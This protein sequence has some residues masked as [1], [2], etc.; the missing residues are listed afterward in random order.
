MAPSVPPSLLQLIDIASA[1]GAAPVADEA[2]ELAD[3]VS[4]GRFFVACVGQ[5]K[6]G[7]STFLNAL[8]GDEVL[9]VGMVPVTAAITVISHG[10]RRGARVRFLDGSS[11]PITWSEVHEYIAEEQNPANAKQ[12]A[13]VEI[14]W[15]SPVLAD[16][17]CLVDTP[18]IGSVFSW[19]TET[20]RAFMPHVD[21]A[22]VVL[23][24]D[25]P[26]SGEE[27]ALVDAVARQ[28]PTLLFALN[29]MDRLT[30]VEQDQTVAFTERIL[31]TRLHLQDFTLYKVSATERLYRGVPTRD[32]AV[33]EA[34]LM[35]LS[36]A[37]AR[38]MLAR[39][40]ARGVERLGG[41]LR[42][43]ID[44][45]TT[46]LQ[47]PPGEAAAKLEALRDDVRRV[48]RALNELS[49]SAVEEQVEVLTQLD[50]RLDAFLE[51][52][53]ARGR[54]ELATQVRNAGARGQAGR[55]FA[56]TAA[57]QLVWSL[58][59]EWD[60]DVK[61]FAEQTFQASAERLLETAEGLLQKLGAT[62]AP[63]ALTRRTLE[64][65]TLLPPGLPPVPPAVGPA[66]AKLTDM[67]RAEAQQRAAIDEGMAY[68]QRV[69]EAE[70]ARMLTAAKASV[71]T[72]HQDLQE[73]AHKPL[74]ELADMS[75]RVLTRAN[76]RQKLGAEAVRDELGR[77]DELRRK[78]DRVLG[79]NKPAA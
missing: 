22:V 7:K 19:N 66:P 42:A 6:R 5:F 34:E 41:K 27:L 58:L 49:A 12:V 63:L 77:L 16:G 2:F 52:T 11:I 64:L 72:G 15:P 59:V 56:V 13:A 75:T 39:A 21:A 14:F 29:K 4:E 55:D 54:D 48:E 51:D 25:P 69:L 38:A 67:F 28:T 74:Q 71:H 33:M 1:L 40:L 45:R 47:R 17:L 79:A 46:A 36:G 62:G 20:T 57:Q 30:Q 35:D 61:A 31:R 78:L 43:E 60:Q 3:R 65:E 26:I 23:G 32:W 9:P 18:G 10:P 8:L 44:Q 50:R 37:A 70:C 53:T 76:D 24:A 73:A 68:L